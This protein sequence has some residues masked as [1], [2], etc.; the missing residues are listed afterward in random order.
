MNC[1]T[2]TPTLSRKEQER[3]KNR[4]LMPF[5]ACGRG[6][7]PHVAWEGEDAMTN[8]HQLKVRVYFEDTDAEGVVYYASYLRFA[9]RARTEMMREAGFEHAQIFRETGVCFTVVSCR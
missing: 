8:A 9:E 1:N 2:L 6:R 4:D 3:E 7:D 5:P